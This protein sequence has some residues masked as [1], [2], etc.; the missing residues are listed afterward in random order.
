MALI[1]MAHI[2]SSKEGTKAGTSM[3]DIDNDDLD[4]L[5][6]ADAEILEELSKDIRPH[7]PNQFLQLLHPLRLPENFD[8]FGDLIVTPD[9]D[10]SEKGD[11]ECYHYASVKLGKVYVPKKIRGNKFKTENE[12]SLDRKILKEGDREVIIGKLPIMVKFDLCWTK[13]AKRNNCEFDHGEKTFIAQKQLYLKRLGIINNPGWTIAYKSE[14]KRNRMVIKLEFSLLS[15]PHQTKRLWISLVIAMMMPEAIIFSLRLITMLMRNE[16]HRGEI[17]MQLNEWLEM[18]VFLG[19]SGLK[20]KARFLVYRGKGLLL[21]TTS[22]RRCDSR[23]D[24]RN[25]RLELANELLEHELKVHIAH[26]R[27]RM[28]KAL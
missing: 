16:E 6:P 26:A 13:D 27:K 19:I 17:G 25:K 11:N 21:A 18:Y 2:G 12:E 24:F 28:S 20:R 3:M 14:M 1:S 23:D 10:P 8:S 15:V 22:R 9:F 7:S 5:G 4:D